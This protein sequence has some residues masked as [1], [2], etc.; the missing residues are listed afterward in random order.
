MVDEL[1]LAGERAVEEAKRLWSLDVYDPLHGD[2]RPRAAEC[3][4]VINDII[5]ANGWGANTEYTGNGP[6]Q[7]CGMFAGKCWRVA[8]LDPTWLATYWAS[9]Y[10]LGLWARYERF[11]STSKANPAPADRSDRRL[12]MKIAP[13]AVLGFAPRA[14]DI[15]IVGD[16]NPKEGDHVTLNVGYDDK[17]RVFDTI[18]GNGGGL[19][20]NGNSREGISRREFAIDSVGYRAMFVIRPAFGDLLAERP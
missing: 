18:S 14:G 3:L 4:A 2:K 8:S 12:I 19:G 20:P 5:R 13:N 1:S 9:T 17:R 16:G 10:R 7:W 11:A 6:P 15:V